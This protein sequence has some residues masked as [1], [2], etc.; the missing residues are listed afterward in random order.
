MGKWD[1]IHLNDY[2]LT[3]MGRF[4]EHAFD[5][6][7]SLF[8]LEAPSDQ[9]LTLQDCSHVPLPPIRVIVN[10]S[11]L[12]GVAIKCSLYDT[13]SLYECIRV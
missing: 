10:H 12:L 13:V 3:H 9:L 6:V 1:T 11:P 4:D 5:S 8:D 7:S 2:N